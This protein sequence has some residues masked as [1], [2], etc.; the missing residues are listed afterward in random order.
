MPAR[1]PGVGVLDG[2]LDGDLLLATG[3]EAFGG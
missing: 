3:E 1:K 2:Y